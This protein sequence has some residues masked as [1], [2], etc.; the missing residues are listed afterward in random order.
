MQILNFIS[1]VFTHET[2][3]SE[4]QYVTLHSENFYEGKKDLLNTELSNF[5]S[6]NLFTTEKLRSEKYGFL[7]YHF[8]CYKGDYRDFFDF[9][10]DSIDLVVHE[11]LQF[12]YPV[13]FMNKDRYAQ[14]L[15]DW[16]NERKILKNPDQDDEN[17]ERN[18]KKVQN[19]SRRHENGK[20][21]KPMR[22]G[23]EVGK[24]EIEA[25]FRKAFITDKP[26]MAEEQLRQFLNANFEVF[27]VAEVVK[28][29]IQCDQ[30]DIMAPVYKFYKEVDTDSK[31]T[32][33]YCN[34]M[35]N[36]FSHLFGEYVF[37]DGTYDTAG[38][39]RNFSRYYTPPKKGKL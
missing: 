30:K 31:K 27:P 21:L 35:I 34:M 33:P 13:F 39:G 24:A 8:S 26:I 37:R 38:V 17:V 15:R 3:V 36:N 16:C 18:G 29:P 28:I 25:Y 11:D 5:Y 12:Y 20:R 4:Y 22:D 9:V 32:A 10:Y 1:F 7:D 23:V 14:V 2:K 19:K 6:D